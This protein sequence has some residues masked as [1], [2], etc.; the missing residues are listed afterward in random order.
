MRD[1]FVRA[2]LRITMY[3][4]PRPLTILT[5]ASNQMPSKID[6]IQWNYVM[7]K[8]PHKQGNC[9]DPFLVR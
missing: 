6:L 2:A 1:S 7:E 4:R 8:Q 5:L 9:R 3:Q